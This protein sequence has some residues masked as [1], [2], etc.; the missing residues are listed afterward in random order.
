MKTD[1][2]Y[3]SRNNT[4]WSEVHLPHTIFTEP[5]NISHPQ[6]GTAFYRYFFTAPEDWKEKIVSFEIGAAM[7]KAEI[8]VNG[9]YHFTHFGGYQKFFIPLSDDLKYGELNELHITLNNA[10]SRDMPPGKGVMD[11][12]FCYHSGLYRSAAIRLWDPV[13]ITDPLAVSIPAGGGVF[14]RTEKLV[15]TMATL[16]ASCHVVH[17]IAASQR[18]GLCSDHEQP[19]QVQV[20]L[21]IWDPAGTCVYTGNTDPVEIRPNCDHTFRFEP[22]EIQDAALWTPDTPNLYH[23]RFTVFHDGAEKDVLTERF[24]I[25]INEFKPDGFYLNGVKTFMNGT[26]RHMEYPFIGNAVPPNAQRRDALLI[27]QSG[28][29]MVRLS[30]YNQDPAFLDACDELGL[31]VL[32]AIPGWQAY[33][34]NSAFLEN[35]YR[36]CRELIRS[37]RN[38]PC[39]MFWEVSLNEAYPPAWVNAEFHRIAHEE[40]PGPYCFSAGDTW[41]FYEG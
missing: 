16:T 4:D 24:G 40:Y 2:W 37:L 19:N 12:D 18:F 3:F 8:R 29:N 35:A 25:R 17:E 31:M 41:G 1:T 22:I 28:Y 20:R 33:H 32:P 11:L 6:T 26:N 9:V 21:E 30:H 39:V 13:H 15:G 36:D 34:G 23:A 7:Q 27:K 38:R 14:L 5:E 10:P